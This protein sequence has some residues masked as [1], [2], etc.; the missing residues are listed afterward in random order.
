MK[1]AAS[2]SLLLALVLCCTPAAE[3]APG[4]YPD[5]RDVMV[6][7]N[8]A[9]L[10]F[11]YDGAAGRT[12]ISA[13]GVRFSTLS[14]SVRIPQRRW[15][16]LLKA[17]RGG[18]M[19]VSGPL[20]D[21]KIYVSEDPV[22]EY[23]TYRLIEPGYEVWD[24]VEIRERNITDFSERVL[25]SWE[26]TGN[27]CMNCHTHKGDNSL[28]YIRGRKGG[29]LLNRGGKLRYLSLKA[30]GM[31]SGTVYGDLHPSGRWGVFSTNVI[32]PGFHTLPEKR[33][34]VY[35]SASDLTV[36]DFEGNRMIN[37]PEFARADR[38][39]TF[40]CFSAD[41]NSVFFCLADTLS[42]PEDIE[43]LRYSLARTS[44]DP[45]TGA[46]GP[47]ISI[48]R[49]AEGSVC[50]P[51]ASPDGRFLMYTV[52]D[53]GTFPLWHRECRLEL[54]NLET[55]ETR[56]LE[57]IHENASDSYHSW[58]SDSRW[59]VFASKRGDGQYGKPYFCHI[60]AQGNP[61]KPFVLPQIDPEHYRKTLK[62]YNIPDLGT[63]G[64]P[65][66]SEVTG[67]IWESTETEKFE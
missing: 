48:I 8:I 25:C 18:A 9:P 62:S 60:D 5:Y 51:K 44:F 11:R 12:V 21:W 19:E 26:N 58:S 15:A 49:D 63:S 31:L 24:R 42:L 10:N 53:Y 54:M 66:D 43:S 29:A 32:I 23:L 45:Q 41:G 27:S 38:L 65:Y 20:G 57:D 55:G 52:A 59:F 33:M 37:A 34:E 4:V 61:S 17:A 13:P 28:F 35:D 39:E 14:R 47:E 36:A 64:A 40:P 22:D 16:E 50:H 67:R 30:E 7:C 56:S 2:Y 3:S 46:L 1:H 6:P